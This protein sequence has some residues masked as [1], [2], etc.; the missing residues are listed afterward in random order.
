MSE[1][2]NVPNRILAPMLL[3]AFR[4]ALGRRTAIV[5]QAVHWLELY[6]PLMERW[7]G[8]IHEDIRNAIVNFK[9]GDE[10]DEKDWRK[11]LALPVKE[12]K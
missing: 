7:H 1:S 10:C 3:C 11:V 2:T 6:W 4:Y 8:Q 9:A 5:S 12:A